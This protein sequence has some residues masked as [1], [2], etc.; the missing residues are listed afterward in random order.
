LHA[1]LGAFLCRKLFLHV[2]ANLM[3]DGLRDAEFQDQVGSER[4]SPG[5]VVREHF[6]CRLSFWSVREV[7]GKVLL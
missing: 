7:V 3:L 6:L 2:R 1:Q 5:K 4:R